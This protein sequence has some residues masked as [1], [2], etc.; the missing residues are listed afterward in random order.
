MFILI[1]IVLEDLGRWG[2][3][4]VGINFITRRDVQ[5]LEEYKQFYSTEIKELPGNYKDLL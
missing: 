2:R 1:Y 5:K 3:K 4:G